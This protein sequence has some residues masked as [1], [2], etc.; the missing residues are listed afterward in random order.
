MSQTYRVRPRDVPAIRE[1][2]VRAWGRGGQLREMAPVVQQV[3]GGSQEW[4]PDW[5]QATVA[6]ATLWYVGT[7]MCDLLAAAAPQLPATQLGPDLIPDKAGLVV[8]ESPLAG[9]DS[10]GTDLQVTV[11]CMLWGPA[12]W[13]RNN[14]PILGISIYGPWMREYPLPLGNLIWPLGEATDCRLDGTAPPNALRILPPTDG[15]HP[16]FATMPPEHPDQVYASM[17]E[18]RRRLMA[19]WLLSRQEGLATST[20]NR[21]KNKSAVKRWA[22]S[23]LDPEVRVVQLRHVPPSDAGAADQPGRTYRHRWAV[24]GHWRNQA[25]GEAYAQHRPIY[26]NPYLKGPEDAPLLVSPKVKAWTR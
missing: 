7:G 17:A 11:G 23:Q 20:I 6:E 18:D 4:L 8:F 1:A 15:G 3:S 16:V 24:S 2:L 10:A 9:I 5:E 22:R 13:V 26:I 21:P 25:F 14:A 19:L 12:R